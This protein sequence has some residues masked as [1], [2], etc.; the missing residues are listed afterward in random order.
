MIADCPETGATFRRSE[1]PPTFLK[2]V[3][4]GCRRRLV[5]ADKRRRLG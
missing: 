5:I 2:L 4:F 1:S 3:P